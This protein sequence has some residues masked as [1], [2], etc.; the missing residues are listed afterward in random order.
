[1]IGQKALE[2]FKTGTL[3]KV[4]PDDLL[5]HLHD[6]MEE[7]NSETGFVTL[8]FDQDVQ[9]GEYKIVVK[10]GLEKNSNT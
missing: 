1:M 5:E 6:A 8:D 3:G 9:E 2:K 10:I 4:I 7:S